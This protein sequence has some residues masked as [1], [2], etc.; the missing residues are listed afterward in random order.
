MSLVIVVCI[1]AA[2]LIGAYWSR[3]NPS[4]WFLRDRTLDQT[5]WERSYSQSQF[6]IVICA[7][8]AIGEAFLLRKDDIYRLRPGDR[9]L[10]I[11]K[12]AYPK[13]GPDAL[14]IEL[15]SKTLMKQFMVPEAVLRQHTDPSVQDV[16][17]LC[18]QYSAA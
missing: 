12:A 2:A 7:L 16:L 13:R 5:L 9:L 15:L 3:P 14:E 6:P 8:Q 11:Y 18:L 10:A 4:W 17:Q 1:A